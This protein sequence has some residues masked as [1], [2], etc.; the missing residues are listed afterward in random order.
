MPQWSALSGLVKAAIILAMLGLVYWAIGHAY[1]SVKAAGYAEAK[2]EGLKQLREKDEQLAEKDRQ[3]AAANQAAWREKERRDAQTREAE[4][5]AAAGQAAIEAKATKE[6]ANAQAR[7]D[8]LV[9]DLLA[10]RVRLRIPA[11][12]TLTD[13]TAPGG[14]KL[15]ST[16]AG[17]A[18]R[19]GGAACE[20]PG[21]TSADLARLA[22]DA[23]TVAIKLNKANA[24]ILKDRE[25][26]SGKA[27]DPP[28]NP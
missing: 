17:T 23:D 16:S 7:S 11:G 10:G 2:A 4:Q 14:I 27:A 28:P 26:C 1:N 22:R 21:S 18:G 24:V 6:I 12:N 20:L 8:K 3:I 25:L 19:E 9:D 13:A 5:N 15:P